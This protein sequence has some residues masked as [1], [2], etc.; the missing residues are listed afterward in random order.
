MSER[1]DGQRSRPMTPESGDTSD[2]Q[3]RSDGRAGGDTGQS[4]RKL[5]GADVGN[6]TG[7]P[8]PAT[9]NK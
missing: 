4:S 8:G 7:M 9:G 5:P 2:G 1:N 3:H 6:S